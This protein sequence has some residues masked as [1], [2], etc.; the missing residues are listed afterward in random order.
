M[1]FEE[2]LVWHASPTLA[3]LK[4]ANLYNFRFESFDD[5][6]N[7]IEKYNLLMNSKGIYIE[8]LSRDE[9]F[10]LIYVYRKSQ[11]TLDLENDEVK[12]FLS[13]YGYCEGEDLSAYISF[14]KRRLLEE[15]DFPHEIGVFLG[16]PLDDVKAFI[17]TNGK[18]CTLCGDWKVYHDAE[19]AKCLFC[20]YK[21][22]KEVYVKVYGNG[23]NF[24]DML[25]G[26]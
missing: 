13:D 21:H 7:T 26:A 15:Q 3:S 2:S 25:V 6:L 23:R 24:R 19:S 11:L 1:S 17:K 8:L 22:C 14:L 16:Y 18:N 12:N 20:K 10:Y 9:D 5:C 4:V